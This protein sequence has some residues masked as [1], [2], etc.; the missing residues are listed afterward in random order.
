[1]LED[2]YKAKYRGGIS[3]NLIVENTGNVTWLSTNIF[4]SSCHVNVKYFPFDQQS[5]KM[6]LLKCWKKEI[7]LKKF[8]FFKDCS[9][10]FGN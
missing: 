3:T 10:A 8:E 4:K 5:K 1:M 6:Y 7:F 2:L 9:L